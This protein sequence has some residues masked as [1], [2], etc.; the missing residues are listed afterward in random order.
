MDI[1]KHFFLE[2]VNALEWAAHEGSG[3]TILE[4]FKKRVD[5]A[6]RNIGLVG[7]VILG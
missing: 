5:R 2:S 1:R 6:L 3:V 7:M 4:V